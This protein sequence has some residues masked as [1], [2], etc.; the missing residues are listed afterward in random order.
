MP[1]SVAA[2][3]SNLTGQLKNLTLRE[4]REGDAIYYI[5]T[6][7]VAHGETLIFNVDVTPINETSR[8]SIRFSRQFYAD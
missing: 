8:F 2:Q 1:G 4:I 3:A 5:G 6:V 7:P